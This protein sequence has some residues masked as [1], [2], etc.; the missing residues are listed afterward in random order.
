[1]VSCTMRSGNWAQKASLEDLPQR[2]E[3][4]HRENELEDLPLRKKWGQPKKELEDLP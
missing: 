1:M 3:E 2:N 4:G